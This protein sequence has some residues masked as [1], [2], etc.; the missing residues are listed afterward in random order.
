[1][2]MP[3]GGGNQICDITASVGTR[4]QATSNQS[5]VFV[6]GSINIGDGTINIFVNGRDSFT[7]APR[8][9]Q[10]TIINIDNPSDTKTVSIIEN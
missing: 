10:V 7:P 5:W 1:V 4:W 8:F 9:A 6:D 3:S 2:T